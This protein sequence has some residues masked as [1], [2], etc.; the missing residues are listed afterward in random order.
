MKK[1]PMIFFAAL[2]L[3][4]CNYKKPITRVLTQAAA[5]ESDSIVKI[6]GKDSWIAAMNSP[7]GKQAL[8][9][10][11]GTYL[12]ESKFVPALEKISVWSCPRDFKT[13]WANYLSA[14]EKIQNQQQ[15]RFVKISGATISGSSGGIVA[16]LPT[17]NDVLHDDFAGVAAA[18]DNVK[19]QAAR[20]GVN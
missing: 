16:W 7:D 10:G 13:A 11:N 12:D 2:I 3:C 6:S 19:A 8:I 18:A 20:Y 15:D 17:L 5:A 1:V 4:G 9:N 14:L